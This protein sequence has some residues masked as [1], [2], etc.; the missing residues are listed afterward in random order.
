MSTKPFSEA[1]KQHKRDKRH[2][3][4]FVDSAQ[5]GVVKEDK[6]SYVQEE[7]IAA[8]DAFV[9]RGISFLGSGQGVLTLLLFFVLTALFVDA[10]QTIQG[11]YASVSLLDTIYL[12]ALLSLLGG[13]GIMGYQNYRQIRRLKNGAKMQR[14]FQKQKEQPDKALIPMTLELLRGYESIEESNIKQ[15]SDLLRER[16]SSSHDYKAIYQ[17]L[18]EDVIEV[19]DV[20]VQKRIKNASIQAALSTAISPLAILDA[21]IIVWRA[22]L[23]TKEIAKLYGFKPGWISTIVLLKKGAFTVF[24]AGA[25]ELALEYVNAA[26]ESTVI[27]KISLSAGQGVG[28][29][30]LLARL[31]Y[32]VMEACRPLP[33]RIKRKS[34][35][36]SI[37]LL[38][39]E[40][41]VATESQPVYK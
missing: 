12:I 35:L 39:K 24:F 41:V 8:K 3:R 29:G 22:L 27:S 9:T 33:M 4:P 23:L 38:I 14:A 18:D 10:I 30:V 17:E 37:L 2:V 13:L 40:K 31:G 34:F 16:I 25:T 32:G 1:V 36:R 26:S 5:G 20:E 19:I 21:G 11:L 28:N 7:E 6:P 15:Q